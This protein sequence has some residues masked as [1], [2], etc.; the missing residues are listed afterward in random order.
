MQVNALAARQQELL[1]KAEIL[2]SYELSGYRTAFYLLENQALAEQAA[3]NALKELLHDPSFFLQP[4]LIQSK[5]AK[6]AFIKHALLV[7]AAACELAI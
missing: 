7:K 4:A 3:L 5:H 6:Q 1:R 2:R